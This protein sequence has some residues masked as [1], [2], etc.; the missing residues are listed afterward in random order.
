MKHPR[1]DSEIH[2]NASLAEA[3][4]IANRLVPEW[5]ERPYDDHGRWKPGQIGRAEWRHPGVAELVRAIHVVV[6]EPVDISARQ[7]AEVRAK[8]AVRLR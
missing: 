6:E 5:V 3:F 7:R 1:D 4:R 8:R 2:V